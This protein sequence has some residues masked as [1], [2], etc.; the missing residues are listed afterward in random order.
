[1]HR[2]VPAVAALRPP[3][4]IARSSHGRQTAQSSRREDDQWRPGDLWI[5]SAGEFAV[6]MFVRN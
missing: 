5:R 3:H 2:P 6:R 1:M 4:V